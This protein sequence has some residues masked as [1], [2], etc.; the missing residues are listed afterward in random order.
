MAI[1][2]KTSETYGYDIAALFG[3]SPQLLND[4]KSLGVEIKQSTAGKLTVVYSGSVY[5]S[6]S[7][8]GQAITL[9]KSGSLGPAS[10]Q[11]MAAQF[12]SGL[13]SAISAATMKIGDEAI[14]WPHKGGPSA[15]TDWPTKTTMPEPAPKGKTALAGADTLYQ[16]VEGTSPG[17]VYYTFCL[18]KGA[19][20]AVRIKANRLSIRVEGALLPEYASKLEDAELD[21]SPSHYS[22]HFEVASKTLA[23][24]TLG[25]LLAHVG[26]GAIVKAAEPTVFVQKY[27]KEA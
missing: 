23:V 3:V 15:V 17:S 12:V 18:L 6:V 9:A 14:P 1:S 21:K 4:A 5:G 11:S 13:K 20:I 19:A 25:A 22:A 16:P 8:T 10:K 27:M 7:I 26:I 2:F 24:R